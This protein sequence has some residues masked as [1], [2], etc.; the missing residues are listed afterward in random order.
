MVF[1]NDELHII[2]KRRN[3]E[4]GLINSDNLLSLK[5]R[6]S[7]LN[8]KRNVVNNLKNSKAFRFLNSYTLKWYEARR[9]KKSFRGSNFVPKFEPS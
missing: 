7:N 9:L 2:L 3:L 8:L 5:F 1:S 4:I 6:N